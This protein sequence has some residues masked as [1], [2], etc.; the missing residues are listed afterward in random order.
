MR[1]PFTLATALALVALSCA[2]CSTNARSDAQASAPLP[3]P[4]N[5]KALADKALET[6]LASRSIREVPARTDAMADLDGDG[7]KDLLML[8]D[9]QN[10]C[11]A[12]GCTLLVFHGGKDGY[13][14]VGQ[15]VSVRAP[16][17]IGARTSRGW[18]DLLVNVGSGDEAGTVALEFD[19][20][21]YP[22]DPTMA[23]LLDPTR[24]PSATPLI[25]A[26]LSPR[27]AAQ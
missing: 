26:E 14:L 1:T 11:Q 2:G 16:I 21:A 22:A 13:K 17:A 27:I 7:K 9:D 6:F 25:D 18:H 8:L 24:L 20:T 19:G 5:E 3:A 23:A 12:D 15:S 4:V 10:W